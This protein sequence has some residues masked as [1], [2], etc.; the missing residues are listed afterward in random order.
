MS[1][2]HDGKEW[3]LRITKYWDNDAQE[4]VYSATVSQNHEA[5]FAS[6]LP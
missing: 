4:V 6:D 5:L 1:E 2:D 3:T